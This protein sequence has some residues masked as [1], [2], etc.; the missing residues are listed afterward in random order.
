MEKL[1]LLF[2]KIWFYFYKPYALYKIS[3]PDT[4]FYKGLKIH[5]PV[6]VFHPGLFFS[7]EYLAQTIENENIKWKRFLEIGCGSGLI[8]L[9]AASLDAEV[10]AIDINPLAIEITQKNAS[11]NLLTI[12]AI[13]SSLFE[14][15]PVQQ[16]DFIVFNPP[17]Y[18]K[19]PGNISE[20]AWFAGKELEF[21]KN[22]FSQLQTYMNNDTIIKMVVSEDVDIKAIDQIA[23]DNAFMLSLESSKIIML[24]KNFIYSIKKAQS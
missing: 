19:N 12:H 24:E 11:E 17:Y 15:L 6:G 3:K 8:S 20:H 23:S 16:F 1:R 7:S 10:T 4:I 5:I 22:L 18:K 2:R 13:Q 9:V 14:N 21:F